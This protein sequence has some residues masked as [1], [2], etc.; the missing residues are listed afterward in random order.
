MKF[1]LIAQPLQ[2]IFTASTWTLS[3]VRNCVKKFLSWSCQNKL[4]NSFEKNIILMK[5]SKVAY[6]KNN[7]YYMYFACSKKYS[8]C[9]DIIDSLGFPDIYSYN[10][11][12]HF[13]YKPLVTLFLHSLILLLYTLCES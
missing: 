5:I 1:L 4:E 12:F 7:F 6:S 8:I 11:F 9:I 2:M 3:T 10:L 13:S